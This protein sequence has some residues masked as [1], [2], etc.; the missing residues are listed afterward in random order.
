VTFL[1]TEFAVCYDEIS[2][3]NT[4]KVEFYL[5]QKLTFWKNRGAI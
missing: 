5:G 2:N 1:S 3:S 4:Q